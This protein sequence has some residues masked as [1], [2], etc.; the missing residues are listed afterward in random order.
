VSA[1]ART[2]IDAAR[3]GGALGWKVNGAGGEGGS[4]TILC[5]DTDPTADITPLDPSFRVLP[6]RPSTAGLVVTL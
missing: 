6:I 5:G 3:R 4:V 2:V 1:E